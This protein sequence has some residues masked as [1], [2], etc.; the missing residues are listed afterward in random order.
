[1]T[2]QLDV[3]FVGTLDPSQPPTK[4]LR[5]QAGS[6]VVVRKL[7]GSVSPDR[8]A[9]ETAEVQ[10][11]AKQLIGV[12]EPPSRPRLQTDRDGRPEEGGF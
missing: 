2:T 5:A 1:M 11:R 10:H 9:R 6:S 7:Y 8:L 4:V 3:T 12:N